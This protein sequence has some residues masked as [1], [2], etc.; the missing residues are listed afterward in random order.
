MAARKKKRKGGLP[1]KYARMG[2]GPGWKAYKAAKRGS[3]KKRTTKKKRKKTK[4]AKTT[5][6]KGGG[7][8][9][10]KR[11]RK[12][13]T[14]RRSLVPS[15]SRRSVAATTGK[16]TKAAISTGVGLAGAVGSAAVI[17]MLPI[18][19]A[20]MKALTQA[21]VGVAT[22]IL[23]PKR[24]RNLKIAGA[25]ASL[26]GALALV[27]TSGLPVPLL[28]GADRRIML[29]GYGYRR[30]LMGRNW[31]PTAPAAPAKRRMMGANIHYGMGNG[32][33]RFGP[34][35]LTPACL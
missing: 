2:F 8:M 32:S 31:R 11:S 15:I 18:A 4:K 35:F 20:R 29:G 14:K 26:A 21:I 28:A 23:T 9:K 16:A 33:N 7:A 30:N 22:M 13:S 19:D 17:Q 12:R 5:K 34:K 25:G 10:K 24:S 27:K 6:R 3:G 1:A